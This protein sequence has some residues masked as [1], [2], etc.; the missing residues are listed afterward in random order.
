MTHTQIVLI[1]NGISILGAILMVAIG[2]IKSKKGVLLAQCGQF[3]LLGLSNLLLGGLTGV[4]VD[5]VSII[6]NVYCS[7]RNMTW[8]VKIAFIVIQLIIAVPMNKI[9]WLGWLPIIS[10][11]IF[12][13]FID[14]KKDEHL[15]IL[16]IFTTM[17]WVV[18]DF[19]LMNYTASL[20][21][22]LSIVSNVVGLIMILKGGSKK[23]A[24]G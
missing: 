10:T 19:G 18:Y 16:I 20:F 4:I 14:V 21:D 5:I 7:K 13:L 9:G 1:A 12:T 11:S 2:L 3:T 24:E 22:A 6:R 17:F 15:K 23:V 8:P